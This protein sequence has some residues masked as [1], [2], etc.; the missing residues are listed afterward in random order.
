MSPAVW[1]LLKAAVQC[2]WNGG[3]GQFLGEE[4]STHLSNIPP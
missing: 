2:H 1:N 4:L 3:A